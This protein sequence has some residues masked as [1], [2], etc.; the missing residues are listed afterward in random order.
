M[1]RLQD[2]VLPDIKG[3]ELRGGSATV[4]QHRGSAFCLSAMIVFNLFQSITNTCGAKL[5]A[6]PK[7]H[8]CEEEASSRPVCLLS[9]TVRLIFRTRPCSPCPA[10]HL[11][12]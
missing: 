6:N 1:S 3:L 7:P 8:F 5:K 4:C 9:P 2:S 10:C 12:E 11:P